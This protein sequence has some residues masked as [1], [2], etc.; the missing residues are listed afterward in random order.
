MADGD[1]PED[2]NERKIFPLQNFFF[3]ISLNFPKS[4]GFVKWGSLKIPFLILFVFVFC[5]IQI[6][7]VLNQ[8]PQENLTLAQ[9]VLT[10]KLVLLPPKALTQVFYLLHFFFPAL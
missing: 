5:L 10:K 1:I 7:L 6:A 2:A 4:L 8:S 3:F 9:V